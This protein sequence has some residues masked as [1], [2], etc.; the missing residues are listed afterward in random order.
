MVVGF[1]LRRLS[2][3]QYNVLFKFV[4]SMYRL[5]ASQLRTRSE[6]SEQRVLNCEEFSS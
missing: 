2:K 6:H 3:L 1:V 4:G 5:E